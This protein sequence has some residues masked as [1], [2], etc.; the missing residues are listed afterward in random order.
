M[1]LKYKYVIRKIAEVQAVGGL[2]STN[3]MRARIMLD[4]RLWCGQT[5]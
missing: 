4:E 2:P 1:N 3:E 5:D